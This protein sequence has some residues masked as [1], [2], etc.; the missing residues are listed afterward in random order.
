MPRRSCR[1]SVPGRCGRV[2]RS[3]G[4]SRGPPRAGARA[5]SSRCRWPRA[6][7]GCIRAPSATRRAEDAASRRGERAYLVVSGSCHAA[8]RRDH[9]VLVNVER[10]AARLQNLHASPP[11]IGGVGLEPA[12]SKSLGMLRGLPALATV[13]GAREAPAPKT[14]R[15]GCTKR[16]ADLGA[17]ASSHLELQPGQPPA[18]SG[19]VGPA[20]GQL[21]TDAAPASAGAAVRDRGTRG[22]G[23]RPRGNR[24]SGTSRRPGPSAPWP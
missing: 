3:R 20:D 7:C 22:P 21:L 16:K 1:S 18:S 11:W 4:P 23:R 5:T 13:Q 2:E 6:R 15:A 12:F 8:N 24:P 14:E 19:R 9:R 17:D 10:R